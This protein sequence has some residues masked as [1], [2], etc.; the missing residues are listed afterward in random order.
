MYI[1]LSLALNYHSPCIDWGI[2]AQFN[3]MTIN[4]QMLHGIAPFGFCCSS[5]VHR[6]RRPHMLWLFFFQFFWSYLAATPFLALWVGPGLAK[7]QSVSAW[8]SEKTSTVW[9]LS[10]SSTCFITQIRLW[11]ASLCFHLFEL[12][13]RVWLALTHTDRLDSIGLASYWS[14]QKCSHSCDTGWWTK[15]LKYQNG[16]MN[17]WMVLVID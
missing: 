4:K 3:S 15:S 14:N 7:S 2:N 12:T 17:G 8:E 13:F 11:A 1:F 5:V 16:W 6:S 10:S 9:D